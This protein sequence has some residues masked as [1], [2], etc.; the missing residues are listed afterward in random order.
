MIRM[1][2][3]K[4]SL[5]SPQDI[6]NAIKKMVGDQEAYYAEW[7]KDWATKVSVDYR[8]RAPSR[9]RAAARGKAV[10]A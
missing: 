1:S 5:P 6:E 2:T 8:R 7:L 10:P 3:S 9:K 4:S